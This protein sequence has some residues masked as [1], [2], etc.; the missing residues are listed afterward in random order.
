MQLI[1]KQIIPE[2]SNYLPLRNIINS[3]CSVT[4]KA[5][6][7]NDTISVCELFSFLPSDA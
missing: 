7:S 3:M 5:E 6:A 2:D 1:A 4:N